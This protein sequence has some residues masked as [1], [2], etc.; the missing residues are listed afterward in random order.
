[1]LLCVMAVDVPPLA[2]MTA[3]LGVERSDIFL[4]LPQTHWDCGG[5]LMV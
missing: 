1:M 4:H 3:I 5:Y 2:P